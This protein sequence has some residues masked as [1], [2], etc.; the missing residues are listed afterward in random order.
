MGI[1][2][3]VREHVMRITAIL[4]FAGAL[5]WAGSAQAI[6]VRT[7]ALNLEIQSC[8]SGPCGTQYTG[9]FTVAESALT[10]DGYMDVGFESFYLAAGPTVWDSLNPYPA[11]DYF[12]SRGS[13]PIT[14]IHGFLPWTLLVEHG[15]VIGIC[16][17]VYGGGDVPFVD[18]YSW[19][20]SPG[21]PS[22][23]HTLPYL[24]IVTGGLPGEGF[25]GQGTFLIHRVAEPSTFV[26]SIIGIAVL[27]WLWPRVPRAQTIGKHLR[28]LR[29]SV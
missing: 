18:L 16:C 3:R 19:D 1:N 17:G 2:A 22:S 6:P 9:Y 25:A 20:G 10:T 27:I 23:F 14:G 4:L 7:Y 24:G 5:A 12:G 29:S 13:N 21:F 26:L 15:E 11:S 8:V 28:E